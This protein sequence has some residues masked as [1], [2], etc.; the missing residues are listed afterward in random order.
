MFH[1]REE[2]VK[3]DKGVKELYGQIFPEFNRVVKDNGS[4]IMF[5]RSEYITYAVDAAKSNE[6]DNKATICWYKTNPMPQVRKR[7]YLSSIELILWVARYHE[8]KCLYTLNFTSQ[9]DMHNL[10][11]LPI[12]SGAERLDHPTQKPLVLMEKFVMKHSNIDDVILDPFAGSG[13]TGVAS[14]KLGRKFLG[15]DADEKYVDMAN[16]R[17]SSELEKQRLF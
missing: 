17:L 3:W 13:T 1:H 15:C 9:R 6:F 2:T 14:I 8:S 5:T 4:V 11:R 7:N 10:I 16:G 12:C